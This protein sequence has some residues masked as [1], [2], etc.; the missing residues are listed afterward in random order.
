L[1]QV[2]IGRNPVFYEGNLDEHK[3]RQWLDDN[4]ISYVALSNGP[5]DWAANREAA[6]VRRGVP[7][8]QPVWGTEHGSF[9]PC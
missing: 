4:A 9:M 3:Y 5:Y 6:L 2:D 8:L 7:Y 1:R